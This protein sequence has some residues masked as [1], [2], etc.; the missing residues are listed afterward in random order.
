MKKPA[1]PV[2]AQVAPRSKKELFAKLRDIIDAG[3]QVMPD[4]AR[5]AGHG[6]P[7]N[8]LEDLIGL[9]A[10][11]QDIAD[12]AGWELKYYTP[13]TALVTLFHKDPQPNTALRYLVKRF[14]W[15]DKEGRLSFRHTI[16]GRTDRFKIVDDGGNI[17]VRPLKGNGVVPTWTHDTLLNAAAG[18]LRRL[19]LVRGERKG[20]LVRFHFADCYETL[21]LTLFMGELVSGTV[22][23][24]FD[25]RESKPGSDVM[26]N[27][28]TKFRVA[29]D[30]ICRLYMRKERL[31]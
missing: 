19:L 6:G 2:I 30:H 17:I 5:S 12:S 31:T 10:G 18:K 9:H 21:H 27:H 15:K 1:A 8:F 26:R 29:P 20:Q 11:N 23:I 13:K 14:G 22:A 7:G 16:K 4:S 28:G 3:W 25:V 24:D